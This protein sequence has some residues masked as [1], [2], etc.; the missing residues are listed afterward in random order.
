MS[1]SDCFQVGKQVVN[2]QS[3]YSIKWLQ[4]ALHILHLDSSRTQTLELDIL[5]TLV[6]AYT[7]D[8]K[9]R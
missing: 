2:H 3:Y 6:K 1:A 5:T 7:N 8:G 4:E 9:L